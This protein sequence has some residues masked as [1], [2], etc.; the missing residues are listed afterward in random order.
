M[1]VFWRKGDENASCEDLLTAMGINCGSM[2]STFGD[3]KALFLKAYNRYCES[4]FGRVFELLDSGTPLQGV[5]ALVNH[6]GEF[7]KGTG[8]KGCL[9]S[10][11]L[12]EF[13][14][15]NV[16]MSQRAR[17]TVAR[18]RETLEKQ[19]TAAKEA[20][21]LSA[22]ADPAALAVFLIN[23]IQGLTVLARAG[24]GEDAIRG[25]IDTTLALL[26]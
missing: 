3:K 22:E 19:L 12:I 4:C 7:L 23:T 15:V 6:W 26:K 1:Q 25:V 9:V 5:R 13:G 2:Y 18:M 17:D 8:Y 24:T 20:G 11:T 21:E 16:E 10:N 14:A